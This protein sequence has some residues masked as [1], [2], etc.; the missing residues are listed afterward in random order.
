MQKAWVSYA[1][2]KAREASILAPA[3]AHPEGA[4][5]GKPTTTQSGALQA[6]LADIKQELK[7]MKATIASQGGM[8]EHVARFTR[9]QEKERKKYGA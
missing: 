7:T 9:E 5:A 4:G 2:K 8:L 6:A 1:N 3:P